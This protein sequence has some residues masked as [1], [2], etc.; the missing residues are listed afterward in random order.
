MMGAPMPHSPPKPR[1]LPA[2]D[3]EAK[4]L[5]PWEHLWDPLLSWQEQTL[6]LQEPNNQ[7]LQQPPTEPR[8]QSLLDLG[9]LSL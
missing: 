1:H 3:H 5:H 8:K 7:H 4:H 9:R 2:R 6:H